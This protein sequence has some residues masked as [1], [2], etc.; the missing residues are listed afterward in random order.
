MTCDIPSLFL[1]LNR[2]PEKV[3][4][5]PVSVTEHFLF[6]A[7]FRLGFL[8]GSEP[9]F[10]AAPACRGPCP[11]SSASAGDQ[12]HRPPHRLCVQKQ[13]PGY[14][15]HCPLYSLQIGNLG[16]YELLEILSDILCYLCERCGCL[17]VPQRVGTPKTWG[18][19]RSWLLDLLQL[20]QHHHILF[21]KILVNCG[22]RTTVKR[23][24]DDSFFWHLYILLV[25]I[26]FS[27]TLIAIFASFR[28]EKL[29]VTRILLL[30][31]E[32]RNRSYTYPKGMWEIRGYKIP[33]SY[34]D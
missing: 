5:L 16:A 19:S 28:V 22:S 26:C 25:L 32:G 33:N 18:K 14:M 23:C 34:G 9:H 13:L 2:L 24:S 8:C 11:R 4:F 20:H 30:G 6:S 21:R 31:G 7:L 27:S 1:C 12:G 10:P 29:K 15:A 3:P 17:A